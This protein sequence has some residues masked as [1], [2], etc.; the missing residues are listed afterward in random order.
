MKP[1]RRQTRLNDALHPPV[2]V[3]VRGVDG[4]EYPVQ[5]VYTGVENGNQVFEIVDPPNVRITNILVDVLPGQTEV[6]FPD[7]R[8][9]A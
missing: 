7:F 5:T 3:R 4:V 8:A 9:G 2:N 6:V 1:S